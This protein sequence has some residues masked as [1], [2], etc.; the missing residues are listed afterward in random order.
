MEK[1]L[2]QKTFPSASNP[3]VARYFKN[4]L[5]LLDE[6]GEA[7]DL[8]DFSPSCI[9]DADLRRF[10]DRFGEAWKTAPSERGSAIA[11]PTTIQGSS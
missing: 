4:A 11:P 9:S 5:V 2:H 8:S 10:I 7:A 3:W 1:P 6:L